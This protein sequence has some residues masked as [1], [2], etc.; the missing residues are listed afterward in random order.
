[1][2]TGLLLVFFT[3][4]IQNSDAQNQAKTG[5]TGVISDGGGPLPGAI[6]SII[7]TKQAV[8]TGN[9]GEFTLAVKPGEYTIEIRFIGLK[10]INR[11]IIIPPGQML[12]LPV[13]LTT[14]SKML[15]GVTVA[16]TRKATTEKALLQ[17]RRQSTNIQDA[18]GAEQI[19]KSAS[20]TTAQ[21]L[22][23]VTG[24]TVKDGK[25]VTVRGLS[26]RNVVV[27]LNG[28]RL[29]GADASRSSVAVDLIPAQLLE[30][31]IVEKSM[32]PDKPG[33]ANGAVVEI[34][35]KTIPDNKFLFISA[36]TGINGNIGFLGNANSF[37][38]ANMGF[39]GQNV[40][41]QNLTINY[42]NLVSDYTAR[43]FSVPGGTLANGFNQAIASSATDQAHYNEAV[44]INDIME[45]GFSPYLTTKAKVYSPD[46]IYGITYG[47]RYNLKSGKVIGLII[48]ANYY[49]RSQSNPNGQNNLF[50]VKEPTQAGTG[51]PNIVY[52]NE[53]RLL[54]IYQLNENTGNQQINYGGLATLSFRFNQYN[55]MSFTYNGNFG[56]EVNA[57]QENGIS[58]SSLKVADPTV[59]PVFSD[60][61]GIYDFILHSTQRTL[62]S[63]QLHGEHK[64]QVKKKIRP[65]Q[66]SYSLSKSIATQDDPDYRDTRM[67]VDSLGRIPNPAL[68]TGTGSTSKLIPSEY[69]RTY[70]A[71]SDRYYRNLTEHNSNYKADLTIP[72][73]ISRDT[74]SI[75]KTGAYYYGRR[76]DYTE[77]LFSRTDNSSAMLNPYGGYSQVPNNLTTLGGNLTAW[78]GPGQ[79]GVIEN[80]NVGQGQPLV[81]GYL[82]SPQAGITI[83]PGSNK[84][85]INSYNAKQDITAFYGMF[86]LNLSK[87]WR[88]IGGLRVENTSFQSTPDTTNTNFSKISGIRDKEDFDRNYK[89]N[90]L[91]YNW[92]PS[93]SVIYKGI[94]NFNFR[95]AYSKTL[96]RP[97]L[98][99][100][101]LSAQ[102]DPI[103]Q[104]TIY[105]N[106]DLQNGIFTNYDFRTDWFIGEQE[107]ISV[108]GFYKTV[109][110]QIERVYTNGSIDQYGFVNS[111]VS[112]RNNP[113]QGK[114][115]GMEL[116]I[117]K[118]LKQFFDL[119]KYIY[120]SANLMLAKSQTKIDSTEYYVISLLDRNA[121]NTRPL[122]DQP[123]IA[124]NINID[125][126][127]PKWG[128]QFNVLYNKTGKRLSDI[129]SDGSPNI[130]EMPAPTFDV[131]WS[132][133]ITKKL[134]FKAFV[135]N[136][137]NSST[138]YYYANAGSSDTFGIYNQEYLRRSFSYG[139]VYT[140]GFKYTF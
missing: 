109:I 75:F 80:A 106:K 14:D 88:L 2:K 6:I 90:Y 15:D 53:L 65:W 27:Q 118:N 7:E 47:N 134:Q 39:F 110:N 18:I 62:N 138:K 44:R 69:Q 140:L 41:N 9:N 105:G 112:F 28:S 120:V 11:R 26:D 91:T 125:F 133:N 122:V 127:Y 49:N 107:L 108:S 10:T 85:F 86:D 33:D 100:I 77:S 48:G 129:N 20:I 34:N 89:T 73:K 128:T 24:V 66:L 130:Y 17:L 50:S 56:T 37:Q 115:Y 12:R 60:H 57:T 72:F 135:K 8:A 63:F 124:Y 3:V 21:A 43:G 76:R 52:P 119:G 35:T 96:I 121:S 78:S 126:D 131:V 46:Q 31:I 16:A 136:A 61:Q 84:I 55:E 113:S 45:K 74:V 22:Q 139:S 95:A 81:P 71:E 54:P 59:I 137:F 25:Y 101:V 83:I 70:F 98:N 97:E 32:T 40:K 114:V 104:L 79:V 36:Q 58:N 92:L 87:D 42:N 19:D 29:A 67:R 99:E 38:D 82:Y 116:E 93:G 111:Y 23:R 5:I 123:N 94:K 4:I 13:V 132:Q 68:T 102:R 1:M 64:F 103:Q 30:N 51:A 117:R